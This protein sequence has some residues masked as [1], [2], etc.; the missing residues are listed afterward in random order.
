MRVWQISHTEVVSRDTLT[1]IRMAW[2]FEQGDFC[3]VLRLSPH[4]PG[5]PL[6]ILLVSKFVRPLVGNDLVLGMQLSAQLATALA[7]LLLVVPLFYLGLEL[8]DRRLSFWGTL[9]FQCLPAAGKLFG[10][11]LSEAVFLLC[12]A[13]GLLAASW[14]LRTGRVR[15]FLLAG[16]CSGLA[17]LIRPEGLAVVGATGAVLLGRQFRPLTRLSLPSFALRGCCL[18]L[19]VLMLVVPYMVTIGHLSAKMG[20]TKSLEG[21]LEQTPD[22][23]QAVVA[24]SLK[25]TTNPMAIWIMDQGPDVDRILW[26]AKGFVQILTR[27]LF[28]YLWPFT[29]L[30]LWVYREPLRRNPLSWVLLLTSLAVMVALYRVAV[31]MGYLSERHLLLVLLGLVYPTAAGIELVACWVAYQMFRPTLAPRLTLALFLAV[32]A[33]PTYKSLE[34]LHLTRT[35]FRQVGYWLAQ[36]TDLA[37]PVEDPYGWSYYYSGRM[38]TETFIGRPCPEA[39]PPPRFVVLEE[40]T[41]NSHP[42][43]AGWAHAQQLTRQTSADVILRR[44]VRH[45]EIRVYDLQPGTN[46]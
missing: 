16:V 9:L 31:V 29:L 6:S 41:G 44:P 1:Y 2:Q 28:W 11:G 23:P 5:Y 46:P 22:A 30:G 34:T 24:S 20:A 45:G 3:Q 14:A 19:S 21:A 27:A 4:H 37:E 13:S 10:D 7:S 40:D 36:H 42:H 18:L 39:L 8:F 17:Y 12:A 35:G 38:F 26:A 32:L 15:Y 33:V 25:L 43:L